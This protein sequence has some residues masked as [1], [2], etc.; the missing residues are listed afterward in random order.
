MRQIRKPKG[1]ILN[2]HDGL[3]HDGRDPSCE[4]YLTSNMQ[5]MRLGR[6]S[7]EYVD[8]TGLVVIDIG[9]R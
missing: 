5:H 8:A 3:C 7:I 2:S 9:H 1:W 6:E 4:A